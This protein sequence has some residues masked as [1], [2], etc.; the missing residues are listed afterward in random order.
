MSSAQGNVIDFG[1][2]DQLIEACGKGLEA[3]I[4][5]LQGIQTSYG[6]LPLAALERVAA[7]TGIPASHL[8][9]V[10]TFYRQFR[11]HPVG[12]N[13]IKVCLGTAC[14]VQGGDRVHEVTRESLG[15]G[16]KLDTTEDALFTVEPVACLGCCSLAPVVM[17]NETTHGR[18]DAPAVRK[19]IRK[20]QKAEKPK[21][22]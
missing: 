18:L 5:L 9:G 20:L 6:Y 1:P 17:V 8:F 11:L 7:G 12:K 10:A 19:L 13:M 2:V 16:E 21:D 3:T 4:P 22:A 14:H 15:I